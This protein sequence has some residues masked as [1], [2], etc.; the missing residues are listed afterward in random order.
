MQNH[1]HLPPHTQTQA[2]HA[3]THRGGC[4]RTRTNHPS[5]MYARLHACSHCLCCAV[6]APKQEHLRVSLHRRTRRTHARLR[7]RTRIRTRTRERAH[8]KQEM[9]AYSAATSTSTS[10]SNTTTHVNGNF[11]IASTSFP[12]SVANIIWVARESAL[13]EIGPIVRSADALNCPAQNHGDE[14]AY[15]AA[16]VL[17]FL[18]G[19]RE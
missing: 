10:T 7:I 2:S 17:P 12:H 9:L 19:R 3:H 18:N 15:C 14:Q 5:R 16:E 8:H 4:T 6:Q 11:A 13:T 1:M